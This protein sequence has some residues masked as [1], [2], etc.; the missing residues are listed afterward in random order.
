MKRLGCCLVLFLFVASSLPAAGQDAAIAEALSKVSAERIK[1]DVY[2]LV[3]FGTRHTV[4]AEDHPTRGIGAARRWILAEMRK[5]VAVSG[6]RL[7]VDEDWFEGESR[8]VP[9]QRM[10]NVVAILSSAGDSKRT[11]LV[12][13]H[14]DSRVS[15]VMN[16]TADAP[17]AVDDASGTA[18]T[19]EL[20]RVMAPLKLRATVIFVAFVGE[21][22]GL[23]G[24]TH[25]AERLKTEDYEID[26]MIGIDIAGNSE[27]GTGLRNNTSV[28]VFSEGIADGDS[29]SREWARYLDST[30]RRYV[31]DGRVEMIYR[32]DRYGRGGDHTPFHRLGFPAV[33]MSEF[34]ENYTHQHQDVR[35]ENGIQ[36]GDLPEFLDYDYAARI[37]RIAGAALMNAAA[38]PAPPKNVTIRGAVSYDTT[39][40]WEPVEGAA[41]YRIVYRRTSAPRWEQEVSAGNGSSFV[42][43]NVVMDNFIFG[44]RAVDAEGRESRVQP[45]QLARRRRPRARR[46]AEND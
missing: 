1:A 20:L 17:G 14:F 42:L 25:L 16:A 37:A 21:E 33:R 15:D 18:I 31:P 22:Q 24:S 43:K 32:R 38:A 23:L 35:E 2:K 6:G 28:R 19:M 39:V 12:G 5:S 34:F 8:R 29:V 10:A 4:S 26:G 13:G 46:P 27:G 3:S 11:Y 45:A 41:G 9:K 44:V 7:S 40:N 36:Y 30:A